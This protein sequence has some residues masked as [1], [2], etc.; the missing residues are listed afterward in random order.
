MR[1]RESLPPGEASIV[2]GKVTVSA[3]VLGE[4]DSREAALTG[5]IENDVLQKILD[6]LEGLELRGLLDASNHLHV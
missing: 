2:G 5:F 1:N 4:L 3:L 6:S